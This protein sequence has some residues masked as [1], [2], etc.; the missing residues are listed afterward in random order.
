LLADIEAVVHLAGIAH[1]SGVA[2]S[3]YDRINHRAT[4]ELAA[5]AL[6][7]RVKRLVF[8]SSIRAQ[9]GPTSEAVLTENSEP[10]PTDAYGR[11]KLAAETAVRSAGV[12]YTILRP[13]LVYGPG[14]KGNLSALARIADLPCPLPF[15]ALHNPRSLVARADL[16]SAIRLAVDSPAMLEQ[17]FIAAHP[18]PSSPA[19]M[20]AALRAGRGRKPGLF[21]VSP[22]VFTAALGLLGRRDLWERLAGQLVAS[23]EKL[24]GAG[25]RP[26]IDT[27]SG[28]SRAS[29]E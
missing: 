20:I 18:D 1:T 24:M 27:R 2:E 6:R 14:V 11:S 22:A 19:E 15:G 10:H 3:N 7:A 28:L 26:M 5:A 8:V 4:A 16:I 21:S 17:T 13:V 29:R 25:W 12:P 9:S 23:P